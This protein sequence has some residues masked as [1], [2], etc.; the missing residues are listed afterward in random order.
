MALHFAVQFESI[1]TWLKDYVEQS[2]RLTKKLAALQKEF[3]GFRS[4][5]P[6]LP[7]NLSEAVI[8]HDYTLLATTRHGEGARSY[9]QNI[10]QNVAR[11]K[12]V[13]IDPI[14]NFLKD[15]LRIFK[16]SK[17][18][19]AKAQ[20]DFDNELARYSG[21]GKTKEPSS[22][23]ED[24]FKLHEAKKAYLK[25][26]MDFCI[27]APNFRASLDR[28]L[29]KV[30]SDQ[31]KQFKGSR[32]AMTSNLAK[33]SSEMERIRG[34]SREI[35]EAEPAFKRELL[36][37]RRQ[38]EDNAEQ[39]VRPSRE[40]E[41]YA[42]S[43]VPYLGSGANFSSPA[44]PG[45]GAQRPQKQGWLFIKT[46]PPKPARPSW[47]RRWFFVKNGLFGWL[48][49]GS[50]SGG[51]E[52]SE[53]VGVL[54][55][56][57][58]PAVQE[59]RRFCFEVKT[60]D[61]TV[62]LQAETQTELLQWINMF[63]LAKRRALEAPAST[64]SGPA[65]PGTDAAFAI[66]PPVGP[67]FAA[68]VSDGHVIQG[69]DDTNS[70]AVSDSSMN[71]AA[72][73]S[74]DVTAPNS[75]R[76]TML[77][78]EGES[79]RDHAARIIQ[80]L[81][82]HRKVTA[83]AQ[84]NAN[85]ASTG[86]IASLISASHNILPVGPGAP[87]QRFEQRSFTMPASTL[88]PSTLANPPAP[89]NLSRRAINLSGE[90]AVALG[91]SEGSNVP[92]GIMANLWGTN[93]WSSIHRLGR[94]R[95]EPRL[96]SPPSSPTPKP[97]AT[98]VD[99]VGI[100]VGMNE[101]PKDFTPKLPGP[102]VSP[103]RIS[104]RKTISVGNTQTRK[105]PPPILKISDDYPLTLSPDD[106]SNL[107][108][109][110]AELHAYFQHAPRSEKVVLVFTAMWNPNE[111][112]EFPGRVYVTPEN[113]YFYSNHFG[114]VLT[115]EI[116]LTTVTEVTAA[117]GRESQ[118]DYLFLHLKDIPRK[119]DFKRITI[120]I[121]LDPLK[122][123]QRR[124]DYLVG[125]ANAETPDSLEEVFQSFTRLFAERR[126]SSASFRSW[127]E[128]A[129]SQGE[130]TDRPKK[131][132][133]DLKASLRIDGALYGEAAGRTGREI[134][135][136]K[137]PAQPVL[138]KPQDMGDATVVKDF[139]TSAKAL[140][141]VMFGDRSAVFQILYKNRKVDSKLR[142]LRRV[143]FVADHQKTWCKVRGRS[144]LRAILLE[145]L[146]AAPT[147]PKEPTYKRLTY[148]TTIFVTLCLRRNPLGTCHYRHLSIYLRSLL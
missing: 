103:T 66:I 134:Q 92:S 131:K 93:N 26:S 50:V 133:R 46:T 40:L 98:S 104:H 48:I 139:T 120:K 70:L 78:R 59:E 4:Y 110:N 107:K 128:L 84:V 132:S 7:P 63:D 13:V 67:E 28:L 101:P 86:G 55:C 10:F 91:K 20:R 37:A 135:K 114:M 113:I 109:H 89:T 36:I 3:D 62:I 31:W 115:T 85:S 51:V 81:D 53:K 57:V 143:K 6:P 122:L 117:P 96:I 47:A 147:L 116:S 44:K 18:A 136:F 72:R 11:S 43:T 24:A 35:E 9:F 76:S 5:P 99:D 8:D 125:N 79:N 29:I 126:G 141:H 1:E 65:S 60:K 42:V 119:P 23:R 19:L 80:K 30:F 90:R 95:D 68:K 127:E 144:L 71:L 33:W 138:Y 16:E 52:E 123:L 54:L 146:F 82:L 121:F 140:F 38:I 61:S 118:C 17:D 45:A 39:M 73:S 112:Q 32:E 124:L 49:Q 105:D 74:F 58:R 108:E 2:T 97:I 94:D 64:E 129:L 87:S 21:Q 145:H 148:I 111:Q 14:N 75:R 83:N 102:S 27:Q 22:L 69:G 100:M 56:S 12:D 15:D 130:E 77:D 34:W 137:L 106:T 41:D 25:T 142:C 88:A